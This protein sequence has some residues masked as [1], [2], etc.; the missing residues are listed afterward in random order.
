MDVK[1][2]I[3]LQILINQSF[4]Y[5]DFF[6]PLSVGFFVC[7]GNIIFLYKQVGVYPLRLKTEP[8]ANNPAI[9]TTIQRYG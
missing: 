7:G 1:F 4:T 6:Y 5:T 9:K 8:F 2:G 3:D